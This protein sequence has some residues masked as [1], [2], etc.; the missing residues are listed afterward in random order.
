MVDL[1]ITSASFTKYLFR[2][3]TVIYSLSINLTWCSL[4]LLSL[5]SSLEIWPHVTSLSVTPV[6]LCCVQLFT[7]QLL[8][9]C[10]CP[11]PVP[12][13]IR[14]AVCYV[15]P[16][17]HYP[18]GQSQLNPV[19]WSI[20][21]QQQHCVYTVVHTQHP[22][23]FPPA[24]AIKGCRTQEVWLQSLQQGSKWAKQERKMWAC[25]T[26][27]SDW[28]GYLVTAH[29]H[30]HFSWNVCSKPAIL[31]VQVRCKLKI[32]AYPPHV[33][34]SISDIVNG[35]AFLDRLVGC[36][37]G[38]C[39]RQVLQELV[40]TEQ[41]D[42]TLINLALFDEVGTFWAPVCLMQAKDSGILSQDLGHST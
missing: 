32:N 23:G 4:R 8:P 40:W 22:G 27:F 25:S 21:Q 7:V 3:V 24:G 17:H 42:M 26:V 36:L 9:C 5:L 35:N 41:V 15:F 30:S 18:T 28:S 33:F 39:G 2:L 20:Q 1:I 29:L 19:L 14:Q 6:V 11:T 37:V 10:P 38:F 12:L 16:R 34:F 13:L 31:A